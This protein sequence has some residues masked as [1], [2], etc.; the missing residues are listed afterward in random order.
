M[1]HTALI[2]MI[3]ASSTCAAQLGTTH[4]TVR[5]VVD[6]ANVIVSRGA[7]LEVMPTERATPQIGANGETV[8]HSLSAAAAETPIKPRQLG[9]V[10]NHAMQQY[11]YING[12]ISFKARPGTSASAFG[13][14]SYPGLKRIVKPSIYI[15]NARTPAEFL[16]VM[17]RLQA[18]HDVEWVEPTVTYGPIVGAPTNP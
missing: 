11:G 2:L 9:V 6:A 17:K 1:K 7:S 12:E 15:V 5:P 8:A 4:L 3:L 14:I 18:R 13:S 16:A 10:Y